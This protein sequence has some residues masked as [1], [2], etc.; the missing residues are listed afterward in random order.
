MKVRLAEKEELNEV[1]LMYRKMFKSVYPNRNINDLESFKK[2][3]F[4][5]ILSPFYY[6]FVSEHKREITGLFVLKI[7]DNNGL[8]SPALE[9]LGT[10]IEEKYRNGL[11]MVLF[12]KKIEHLAD[13]LKMNTYSQATPQTASINIK[14]GGVVHAVLLERVFNG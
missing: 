8:T 5:W 13:S 7:D 6:V 12:M 11:N 9:L 3:C 4:S 10:Y 1:S 2:V 14:G